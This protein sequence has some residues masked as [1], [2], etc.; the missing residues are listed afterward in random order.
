MPHVIFVMLYTKL[1][2]GTFNYFGYNFTLILSEI[3]FRG[4]TQFLGTTENGNVANKPSK[5][6]KSVFLISYALKYTCPWVMLAFI[7][8]I[9]HHGHFDRTDKDYE[10]TVQF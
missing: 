4:K 9:H 3:S 1:S 8:K 10:I 2:V 6:L 7:A 5:L